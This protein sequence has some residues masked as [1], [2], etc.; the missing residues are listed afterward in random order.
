MKTL[1][2]YESYHHGNTKKLL[3]EC[4][5]QTS[6][7]LFHLGEKDEPE[8]SDY[9]CIGF[10]SGV[11]MGKMDEKLISL[12]YEHQDLLQKKKLF[13]ITTC[14]SGSSKYA[15]KQAKE[16][17][18]RGF[19]QVNFYNCKGFDTYGPFGLIGGISKN[20]PNSMDISQAV[21]FLKKQNMEI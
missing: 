10:A 7:E 17:Q 21:Q 11:Y 15:L 14:G 12:L 1:I 16:L 9:D 5:K 20:H 8:F 19:S 13:I 6:I 2:I 18:N 4:Q 3:E